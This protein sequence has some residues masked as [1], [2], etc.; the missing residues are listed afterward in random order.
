[1]NNTKNIV[2]VS[3]Q[4]RDKFYEMELKFKL[5]IELKE[6]N[7]MMSMFGFYEKAELK[8]SVEVTMHQI[9]NFIPDKNVIA[10][11]E[12]TIQENYFK[13]DKKFSCNRCRFVGYNY[14]YAVTVNEE[15]E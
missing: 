15:K 13:N 8:D 6:I 2:L 5:D 9:V 11:Y 12:K 3:E 7:D 1:M 10:S 4:K 14:L